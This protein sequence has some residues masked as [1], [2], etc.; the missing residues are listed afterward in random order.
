MSTGWR[1]W[2]TRR[3]GSR[4][5]S[6][7]R[8]QFFCRSCMTCTYR[9]PVFN[10]GHVFSSVV[11]VV[12]PCPSIVWVHHANSTRVKL[13]SWHR[14]FHFDTALALATL[15][16]AACCLLF[17]G[18]AFA[19]VRVC[20][21]Q[22]QHYE[23][24]KRPRVPLRSTPHSPP[25][26]IK[27][28]SISL[29]VCSTTA[30]RLPREIALAPCRSAHAAAAGHSRYSSIYLS[31]AARRSIRAN[32]DGSTAL[33]LASE[34]DNLPA[35]VNP[36][37]HMALTSTCRDEA[38]LRPLRRRHTWAMSRSSVLLLDNKAPIPR[39]RR[40]HRQDADLL[41][42]RPRIHN[43][44]PRASR[45]RYRRQHALRQRSHRSDVGCGP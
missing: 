28:A 3:A 17:A 10:H 8:R 31:A 35:V 18:A 42:R 6:I 39:R 14:N 23:Q 29:A 27:V 5:R 21:E 16:P 4:P 26:R 24:I 44:R 38:V 20:Q 12:E 30:R 9:H 40:C 22:E 45:S 1:T 34:Q 41:R 32:L 7:A 43:G 36:S 2:F 37:L 13:I 11:L 19:N 15:V 25:L 33:F